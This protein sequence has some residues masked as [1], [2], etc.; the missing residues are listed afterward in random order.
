MSAD[1]GGV[2]GTR[3]KQLETKQM[4]NKI[5]TEYFIIEPDKEPLR[6]TVEMSAK[7]DYEEIKALLE[8]IFGRAWE[9]HVTVEY[10]GERT[11]MFVDEEGHMKALPLNRRATEIYNRLP[12]NSSLHGRPAIVGVAVLFGRRIWY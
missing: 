7:P 2:F 10:K 3:H 8:P 11:D 12:R 5:E 4:T 9:E 1:E 6:R